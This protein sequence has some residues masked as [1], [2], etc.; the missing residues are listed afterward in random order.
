MYLKK[1]YRWI[2]VAVDRY[3]KRFVSFVCGDRS[4]QTGLRLWDKIKDFDIRVFA[5]DFWKSYS[6]FVPIAK[7]VQSKAE[8]YTIEGYNSRIRHYLARFKRKTKCYSNAEYM[9][10]IPLNLLFM[11]LNQQLSILN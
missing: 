3:G 4:T 10:V 7:H 1:N 5:S 6:E 9:I 8:T 2:W 11:K